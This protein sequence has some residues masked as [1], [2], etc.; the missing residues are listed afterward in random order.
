MAGNGRV[1]PAAIVRVGNET[2]HGKVLRMMRT[3]E[4]AR[5]KIE[6]ATRITPSDEIE[7]QW[8]CWAGDDFLGY[9]DD[10]DLENNADLLVA[11][12]RTWRSPGAAGASDTRRGYSRSEVGLMVLAVGL[13]FVAV[14]WSAR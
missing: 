4:A 6:R 11:K 1:W 3:G 10:E 12:I 7:E 13:L 8:C 5:M 2:M 14:L 9:V